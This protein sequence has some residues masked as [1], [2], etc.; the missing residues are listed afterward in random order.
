MAHATPA[1][2]R[3]GSCP[4]SGQLPSRTLE[5]DAKQNNCRDHGAD[6]RYTVTE[7]LE[8]ESG[9]D[10][11]LMQRVEYTVRCKPQRQSDQCKNETLAN[12]ILRK[13]VHFRV[14]HRIS[15]QKDS[16]RDGDAGDEH[17]HRAKKRREHAACSE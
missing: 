3:Q 2:L 8:T 15:R 7:E 14:A 6:K 16:Q 13:G 17:R 12:E 10:T 9:M 11:K 1:V 5:P 4:G